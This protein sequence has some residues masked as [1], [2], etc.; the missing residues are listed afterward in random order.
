MYQLFEAQAVQTPQAVAVQFSKAADTLTHLTYHELNAKANQLA[1]H[2]Q[3]LGVGPETLVGLCVERSL[4]MVV[5]LLGILKAGGAYIPLDPAYPKDR[6]AFML[7]DAQAPVLLT[8]KRLLVALPKHQAKVICLDS[9]WETIAQESTTN[10]TNQVT[11]GNLAYVMYTSGSTGQPKGVMIEHQSL[12]SYAQTAQIQYGLRPS[13]RILQFSSVSFD[14]SVE[15]IFPC[16]ACGA[17]LVLRTEAMLASASA[18]LQKCREWAITVVSL[19]TAF[20]HEL[21]TG[22]VS[23]GLTF[24]PSLRLVILGG[25]RALP[26]RVAAWQ[27]YVGHQVRLVN[28]YGPTEATVVATL[29]EVPTLAPTDDNGR[30]VPIG[31]A[32]RNTQVYLLDQRLQPTPIG[33][34]GE[35]YLG[36]VGLARGYLRQPEL[37]AEKF[38]PNPFQDFGFSIADFGLETYAQSKN[39]KSKI[40]NLKS[41]RLYKTGD[42]ARMLPDGNMEF[43]GRIDD[44]VKIRGFRIEPKEIET[45]LRQHPAVHE[46]VVSPKKMP[47]LKNV[48]WL[49]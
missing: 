31:Q 37:T 9:D 19:P 40:Q 25:E 24:P 1:H 6:L 11:P 17:T 43:V 5:G 14:I 13:D 45:V 38:I 42:L 10:P 2:L 16:L 7:A 48:S 35:L 27:K 41:L 28:T 47:Q 34:P 44:Q 46:S 36:G 49:M 26:E 33:T 23:E 3:A 32:I 12:V 8:Q 21:V 30:E 15:E 29:Y 39:P 22:L 18:F 20:W 4:E